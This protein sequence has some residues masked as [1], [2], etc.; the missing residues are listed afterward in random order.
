MRIREFRR[1][2]RPNDL[3]QHLRAGGVCRLTNRRC[4]IQFIDLRVLT[5]RFLV[6][7]YES[8]GKLDLK[9][10]LKNRI[11]RIFEFHQAVRLRLRGRPQNFAPGDHFVFRTDHRPKTNGTLGEAWAGFRIR[12]HID[13]EDEPDL[14]FFRV[15]S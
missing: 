7:L 15:F 5:I 14:G 4:P 6:A 1:L 12:A 3:R 8:V 11:S 13:S 9:L 10:F 2:G